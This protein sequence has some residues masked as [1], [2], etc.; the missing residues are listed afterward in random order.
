MITTM[1]RKEVALTFRGFECSPELVEELLGVLASEK[2]VRGN[3]VKPGV[4]ASL[5]RSFARFALA[6]DPSSR[7]DQVV[8]NLLDELGGLDKV[9]IVRE[10]VT[11]E[12][13]EVDILWS[14][15][16]SEEQEG[17]FFSPSVIS[18]LAIL[19]CSLSFS[20]V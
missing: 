15:K 4:E 5:K 17:G 13:F 1:S 9:M 6:L 3:S 10:T 16:G 19:K 7:L 2:G 18:D 12:F 14:V 20:F 11:P 8:P